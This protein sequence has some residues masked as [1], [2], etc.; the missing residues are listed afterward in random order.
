MFDNQV[1]TFIVFFFCS[2]FLKKAFILFSFANAQ[3]GRIYILE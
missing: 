1:V 2:L 3:G